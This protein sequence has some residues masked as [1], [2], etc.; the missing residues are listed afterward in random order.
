MHIIKNLEKKTK[1]D[2]QF[3]T[4]LKTTTEKLTCSLVSYN[5]AY[6]CPAQC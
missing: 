5:P 4:K 3:F 2:K 6:N 1:D